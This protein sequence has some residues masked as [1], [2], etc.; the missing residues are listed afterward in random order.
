MEEDSVDLHACGKHLFGGCSGYSGW[1]EK[2]T[3][4]DLYARKQVAGPNILGKILCALRVGFD[5]GFGDKC[6]RTVQA[7]PGV[8]VV[9]NIGGQ[10]D[11]SFLYCQMGD[12]LTGHVPDSK[13]FS[14]LHTWRLLS[15]RICVW[16]HD[17]WSCG[18]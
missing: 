17:F 6:I 14:H 13:M 7:G 4:L 5:E 12:S 16:R 18:T 3:M 11:G 10:V 8:N 2:T 15:A 1:N 9:F